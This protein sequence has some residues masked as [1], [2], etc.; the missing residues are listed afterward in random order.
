M[1]SLA[2]RAI[3]VLAFALSPIWAATITFGGAVTN[4]TGIF[5]LGSPIGQPV[6][7]IVN[8]T[9]SGEDLDPSTGVGLYLLTS[10]T[11]ELF[12]EGVASTPLDASIDSIYVNVE[13]SSSGVDRLQFLANLGG[14]FSVR[15]DF[16]GTESFLNSTSLP[17]APNDLNW[18]AFT[19][20]FGQIAFLSQETSNLL[21]TAEI[22]SDQVAFE[23]TAVDEGGDVPEPSTWV[24]ATVG[25]ALIAVRK[26]RR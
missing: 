21:P 1:R 6:S 8:F 19:G 13:D 4:S 23:L 16:L 18:A 24:L 17:L 5:E 10:G 20:G 22:G 9:T 25:L 7:G 2:A 12:F 14:F 3:C 15:L 11:I 26:R